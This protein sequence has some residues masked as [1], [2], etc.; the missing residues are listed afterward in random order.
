MFLSKIKRL[1]LRLT[2]VG[3]LALG[4]ILPMNPTERKVSAFVPCDQCEE[5]YNICLEGCIDQPSACGFACNFQRNRC[6]RTCTP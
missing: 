3:I 2:I 1:A 6:Y 5:N 4:L